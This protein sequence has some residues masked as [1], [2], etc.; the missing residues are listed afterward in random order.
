M[1]HFMHKWPT[2]FRIY[3]N[4]KKKTDFNECFWVSTRFFSKWQQLV[5]GTFS[6]TK[7]MFSNHL[8]IFWKKFSHSLNI[9]L[10][11]QRTRPDSQR[12]IE[13]QKVSKSYRVD[14]IDS[15]W[16]FLMLL[17]DT[18]QTFSWWIFYYCTW[19]FI[20]RFGYGYTSSVGAATAIVVVA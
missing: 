8:G 9:C 11:M 7:K 20:C 4:I 12:S 2:Q 13:I 14:N 17:K 19:T 10:I 6:Y 15:S 18:C 5:F 16:I 1:T 3:T